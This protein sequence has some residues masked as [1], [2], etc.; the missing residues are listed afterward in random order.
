MRSIR[1]CRKKR[2]VFPKERVDVLKK[3]K[4]DAP[5][6]GQDEDNKKRKFSLLGKRG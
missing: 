4:D 3:E 5:E 1:I 6:K 2:K